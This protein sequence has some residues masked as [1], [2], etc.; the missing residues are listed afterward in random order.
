MVFWCSGVLVFWFKVLG[1]LRNVLFIL[2]FLG[3]ADYANEYICG[4]SEICVPKRIVVLPDSLIN[5]PLPFHLFSIFA[6]GYLR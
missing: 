1:K 3:H 5:T 2:V 4:I 6:K